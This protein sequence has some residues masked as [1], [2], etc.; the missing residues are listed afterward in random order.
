MH[1]ATSLHQDEA[2][3]G[4]GGHAT[5][6]REHF[7]RFWLAVSGEGFDFVEEENSGV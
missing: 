1:L 3:M 4:H 2:S 5:E 7:L 6:K